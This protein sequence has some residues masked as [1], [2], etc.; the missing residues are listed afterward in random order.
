MPLGKGAAISEL[1]S[2]TAQDEG[3]EQEEEGQIKGAEKG[4]V[5]V[6][7]GG[8]ERPARRDHPHFV[9]VP[10]R[11]NGMEEQPPLLGIV[12]DEGGEMPDAV[13]KALQEEKARKEDGDEDEP[14]DIEIHQIFLHSC[15]STGVRR[16]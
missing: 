14:N 16:M 10:D 12:G 8:E 4:S 2:R 3:H 9:A 11:G 7:K 1:D 15:A 6:G 13:V 5:H